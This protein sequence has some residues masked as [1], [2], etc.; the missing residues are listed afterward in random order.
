MASKECIHEIR[1]PN[2]NSSPPESSTKAAGP[3]LQ[4]LQQS[5]QD[6]KQ[7]THNTHYTNKIKQQTFVT[8][9]EQVHKKWNFWRLS[10]YELAG[11]EIFLR[12]W[13]SGDWN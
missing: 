8:V 5:K 2:I 11:N 3:L 4:L 9:L 6:L 1:A 7:G 13:S 12:H 10:G